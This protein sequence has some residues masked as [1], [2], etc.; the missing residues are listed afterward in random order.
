[1]ESR[2]CA[3]VFA[4]EGDRAGESARDR[5]SIAPAELIAVQREARARGLAIVGFYHS[6]PDHPAK[7]SARD[8]AEAYWPECSY[9]IVSVDAGA[10]KELAAYRLE[11]EDG[12][13][14]QFVPE[15]IVIS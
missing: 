4:K 9:V 5:Y 11:A 2:A 10:S 15:E 14:R 13:R 7:P 12:G 6:H 1:M 8:L 3:N